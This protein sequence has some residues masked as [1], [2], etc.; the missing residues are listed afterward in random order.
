MIKCVETVNTNGPI[1]LIIIIIL[2]MMMIKQRRAG[3]SGWPGSKPTKRRSHWNPA[4]TWGRQTEEAREVQQREERLAERDREQRGG[5]KRKEGRRREGAANSWWTTAQRVRS[6][7]IRSK[8]RKTQVEG[9]LI[10]K[11][12]INLLTLVQVF[13]QSKCGWMENSTLYIFKIRLKNVF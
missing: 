9:F 6:Q 3:G 5:R 12:V 11:K 4:Y 8:V 10:L 13:T 2:M 1:I 7:S